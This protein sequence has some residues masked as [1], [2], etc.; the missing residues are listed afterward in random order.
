MKDKNGWKDFRRLASR[1]E[2]TN[3]RGGKKGTPMI[4]CSMD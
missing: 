2:G 1:N 3:E 4:S